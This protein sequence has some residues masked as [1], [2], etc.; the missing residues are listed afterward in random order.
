MAK[1]EILAGATDQTIDIFI[2]DSSS[3]TGGGLTGLVYNTASLTC[4]FRKG[5][6]GTPTA[7]TLATQTVGGAH[8]DGGF[9][10]VDGTNCP[11][12]YR[13]D[14][15]DTI[16]ATAGKATLYLKGAANMAPCVVEIEVV[17]VNKFDAVRMGLTALPNA[18]ADAAGGLPISDAGGLD[19][20]TILA[21][22]DAAITTRLAPTTAGRTLDVTATGAAGIDWG[23]VENPTTVVGL[24][25]T[26]VKTATDVETD[27]ADIQ[28]RIPTALSDGR[29]AADTQALGGNT[30][31]IANLSGFGINGYDP[32]LNR[33]LR[34]ASTDS[35]EA[36][37][38]QAK[39]DVNGEVA[40]AL[41]TYDAVTQADLEARTLLSA[42]YATET[43]L[44]HVNDVADAIQLKT[45]NLP[46][47]PADASDIAGS[48]TTVNGKLDTIDDFLDTEVAAIKAKT[49]QLTFTIANQVDSNALSGGGSG[50]DAAGVRAAVGLASANLDTQLGDI[51]TVAEFEARTIASASYATATALG[52]T[53]TAVQTLTTRLG[54]P[55]VSVS[56]DLSAV[57]A[58]VRTE[59][60]TELGRIDAAVSTRATPAQVATEL[61]TYD[62]PT[63]AEMVARTLAAADYATAANLATVDTVAD[64]ILSGQA[65]LST[66]TQAQVLT[67]VNEA[68]DTAIAEL[69][70]GTPATTPSI[71]TALML[72][73]MEAANES[74]DTTTQRKIKNA[75]GTTIAQGTVTSAT[76]SVTLGKLVSP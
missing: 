76:G 13:L 38:T 8:S 51:P 60:A 29:M 15:S 25:G 37:G 39:A 44:S 63:N 54:I 19:I 31:G 71:R 42:A 43:L 36:L 46:A 14:L 7:L 6:T 47:D 5:A 22:L 50:L 52:T 69:G 35:A 28:S 41:T 61:A 23:N 32:A 27:T 12:Q 18:A 65:S 72:I 21:R 3:T 24:S 45:D 70:I 26:T 58:A 20:D 67:K 73:Y 56:D 53:D 17:S 68:L 34:V 74:Q 1:C 75:A 30:G 55:A 4:Y 16:V 48:F 9:V 57:P 2:R 10:A 33:V 11:G 66:L 40:A 64:S 62:G 59:L 49:D